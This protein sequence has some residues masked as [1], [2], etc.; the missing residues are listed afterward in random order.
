[1]SQKVATLSAVA[2]DSLTTACVS[3]NSKRQSEVKLSEE[4]IAEVKVL[5]LSSEGQ[6]G[7]KYKK[8]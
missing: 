4:E 8:K 7:R 3:L 1:M 2:L 5:F 6:K